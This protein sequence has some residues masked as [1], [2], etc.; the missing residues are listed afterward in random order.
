MAVIFNVVLDNRLSADANSV[1][2]S[3]AT[4]ELAALTLVDGRL[5]VRERPDDAA[6]ETR[7]WVFAGSSKIEGPT[8]AIMGS[9]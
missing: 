1:L 2:R 7:L 9:A 6:L 8:R 4:D 3:R 5:H